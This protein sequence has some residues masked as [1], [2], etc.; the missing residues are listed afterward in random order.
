MPVKSP[1][2]SASLWLR[3]DSIETA[4]KALGVVPGSIEDAGYRAAYAIAEDNLRLGRLVVGDCVNPWMLT[5]DAWRNVGLRAG[6]RVLEIETIC[7]AVDE[8]RRRVE[9][10]V[11]EIPGHVPPTWAEVADLDYRPWN[12]AHLVIDTAGQ[13][14]T[15]CVDQALLALDNDAKAELIR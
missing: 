10:R 6:A 1:G 7:S 4:I 12:R 9:T 11:S 14:L 3:I 2:G 5:R 13:H 15:R 8:H